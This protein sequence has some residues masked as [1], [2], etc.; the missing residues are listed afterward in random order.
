MD[1]PKLVKTDLDQQI[2]ELAGQTDH[3]TLVVW[4]CDCAQRLLPFFEEQY[5]A[6]DRPRLAIEAGRIWVRTGTFKMADIR[7]ASL[8]SHTA[9]REAEDYSSARSAARAAGQAVAAAHAAGHAIAAAVYAVT[10][11]RDGAEASDA[12]SAVKT[13]REWQYHHLLDLIEAGWAE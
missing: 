2:A 5:P 10:A 8:D 1:K 7:K 12:D 3:R 6:D 4:A 11:I 9:A 13:E